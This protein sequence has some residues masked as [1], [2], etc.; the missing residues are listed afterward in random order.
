VKAALKALY[1]YFFNHPKKRRV[2][3]LA[4]TLYV[5]SFIDF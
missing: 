4:G 5:D 3:A 1:R 2:P